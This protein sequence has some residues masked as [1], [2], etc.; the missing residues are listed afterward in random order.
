MPFAAVF[1]RGSGRLRHTALLALLL[2]SAAVPPA[3]ADPLRV[4]HALAQQQSAAE[5]TYELEV[6]QLLLDKT[7]ASHGPYRLEGSAPMTQNRAFLQLVA[8]E[9]DLISS[10]TSRERE[11]QGL[12]LRV[13]LYRG[14]Q[15]VR[16]P[17]ML[18]NRREE[19]DAA[20]ATQPP[21]ALHNGQVADW[22]DTAVLAHNGW[23]VDRLP[24]LGQ[25][26]ELLRRRRLDFVSLG[27]LEAYPIAGTRHEVV[28]GERWA[29]AY[30]SAFYFFVSPTRPE[31][32]ERLRI[33]WDRAL[34]DGSFE[35][36]F[37]QRL[38]AQ[39]R[40][41]RLE[42]RHWWRLENPALPASTPL[43]DARLWHPLVRA[44]LLKPGP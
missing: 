7:Q 25:F 37:E 33:G 27:V 29:I 4:R 31:L 22:P 34:A 40:R 38:G 26:G 5:I 36:L 17:L 12:P 2:L 30:P 1:L 6:L 3:Q 21:R 10:M 9:V 44:R 20:G 32:A 35:A 43:A 11:V 19:L 24:R 16:L 23:Q 13:C 39:L 15:G 14:L 41:A 42:Q 8:G 18:S 28:V